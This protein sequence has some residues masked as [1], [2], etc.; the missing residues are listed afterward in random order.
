MSQCNAFLLSDVGCPL[1]C[2]LNLHPLCLSMAWRWLWPCRICCCILCCGPDHLGILLRTIE[3]QEKILLA[4]TPNYIFCVLSLIGQKV[5]SITILTTILS[6]SDKPE[7]VAGKRYSAASASATTTVGVAPKQ[8]TEV[9]N[10]AFIV[11]LSRAEILKSWQQ[12][13]TLHVLVRVLCGSVNLVNRAE[14]K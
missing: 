9:C 14:M 3:L 6:I 5:W 8:E 12:C 11:C 10:A 2:S 4:A 7:C 1:G 13:Y